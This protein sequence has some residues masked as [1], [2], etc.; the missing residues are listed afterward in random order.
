MK[1]LFHLD[2]ILSYLAVQQPTLHSG[3]VREPMGLAKIEPRLA[4]LLFITLMLHLRS[5]GEAG[6]RW[7]ESQ[8]SLS[9]HSSI[10]SD[11]RHIGTVMA[12]LGRSILR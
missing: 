6:R 10:I 2:C 5:I 12:V 3:F 1:T 8:L 4:F 11:R 9:K 7:L